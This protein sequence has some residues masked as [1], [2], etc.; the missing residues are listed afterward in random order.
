VALGAT[1]LLLFLHLRLLVKAGPLWRDEVNSLVVATQP[2]LA[3]LW[4]RLDTES[5]PWLHFA[6]L[7]A[8]CAAGLGSDPGLRCF[9]LLFGL[10]ILAALW[11]NRR[12]LGPSPPLVSLCLF[13]LSPVA[14][15][16]GDSVRGYGLAVTTALLAFAL[17]FRA[18]SRPRPLEIG[19]ATLAGVAS[20]QALYQNAVLLFAMG[21]AGATVSWTRGRR[22]EALIPLGIGAV[23]ALSL[24]PYA[25]VI[26]RSHATTVV[27]VEPI[28]LGS[29][30]GV[31][32]R[33]LG[34]DPGLQGPVRAMPV[35][36]AGLLAVAV[37]V[38][39]LRLRARA[40]RVSRRRRGLALYAL[41][42]LV[43][44]LPLYLA[45]LLQVGFRTQPWYYLTL[46]GVTVSGIESILDVRT[47]GLRLLRLCG[48]GALIGLVAP[49]VHEYLGLR[50][51]NVDWVVRA[52]GSPSAEDL[53]VVVPWYYGVSFN[54]YYR[55]A[56][57]WTMLPPLEDR[58]LH[59][60]DLVKAM[61]ARE[62]PAEPVFERVRAVLAGG[63][64]LF[65]VG[66]FAGRVAEA[67]PRLPPA[68]TSPS[69]WWQ[70]AYSASWSAQ[71][72]FELQHHARSARGLDVSGGQ[73]VIPYEMPGA[74][75]VEG[76]R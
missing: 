66:S 9:G 37:V 58:S 61:L 71:L 32:S 60:P 50:Q 42:T 73:V 29:L 75:V 40:P 18:V 43:V 22:R 30:L 53:V 26:A 14:I 15:R 12:L 20:V 2:T 4:A 1:G 16:W 57:P 45:M 38:G 47:A 8:W 51:T 54:R 36:W 48:A 56:A 62:D 55:G 63:H 23:A 74:W 65:L 35:V 19:L 39:T 6:L 31:V 72:Q 68:P 69:G 46:M 7:R 21:L 3:A 17:L 44:A 11:L 5:F 27:S 24:L 25:G 34:T 64:R 52:L 59:R 76:W 33:A 10:L 70:G 13:A 67:P 41:L 28:S 49:G